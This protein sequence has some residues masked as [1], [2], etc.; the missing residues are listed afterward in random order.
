MRKEMGRLAFRI[1]GS[2]WNCYYAEPDTMEGAVF[3]GS[4]PM[5]FVENKKRKAEFMKLMRDCF[6]DV[7]EGILG[8]RPD[9]PNPGGH[10]GPENER[11]GNA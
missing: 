11:S 8:V 4:I 7:T 2:N 5:K 6:S 1:E 9:W 10:Q 3:L